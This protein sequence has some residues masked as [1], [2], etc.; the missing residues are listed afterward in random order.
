M[1][2]C[3]WHHSHGKCPHVQGELIFAVCLAAVTPTPFTPPAPQE[4]H[5][6]GILCNRRGKVGKLY[7]HAGI[8][9]RVQPDFTALAFFLHLPQT[10][11]SL[12]T[13]TVPLLGYSPPTVSNLNIQPYLLLNIPHAIICEHKDR[14]SSFIVCSYS[15]RTRVSAVLC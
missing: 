11:L 5:F 12:L 2:R 3:Y 10:F 7:L 4:W 1:L 14:S 6:Q 9:N 15:S 13:F 8:L